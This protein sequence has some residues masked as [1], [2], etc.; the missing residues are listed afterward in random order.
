MQRGKGGQS[1]PSSPQLILS[2]TVFFAD[3]SLFSFV[4][5]SNV[6]RSLHG[7]MIFILTKSPQRPSSD[8]PFLTLT[9]T[10][11]Q[12]FL[13]P[14]DC[15]NCFNASILSCCAGKYQ[16]R[17][18][19]RQFNFLFS[20]YSILDFLKIQREYIAVCL[21]QREQYKRMGFL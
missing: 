1:P 4:N 14:K 18:K 6:W 16:W 9:F 5:I 17:Q 11:K 19:Q 2:P 20:K 10:F 12:S 7:N 3:I 21:F 13:A 15:F 8:I